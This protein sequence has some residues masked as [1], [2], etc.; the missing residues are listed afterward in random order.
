MNNVSD[1]MIRA[2]IQEMPE[3][4]DSHALIFR[5]M[6]R[7]P[8]E[9]VRDAFA[10][11]NENNDP[12]HL[13]HMRLGARFEGLGLTKTRRVTSTNVRGENTENQDWRR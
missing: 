13:L 11:I 10:L 4:F 8:Q 6:Q 2:L 1:D 5:I 9:Y 7:H 12:I 3:V